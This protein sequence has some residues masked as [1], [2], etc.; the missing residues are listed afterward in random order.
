MGFLTVAGHQA[1][2]PMPERMT[3][4]RGGTGVTECR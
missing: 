2:Q 1:T 4:P 3:P